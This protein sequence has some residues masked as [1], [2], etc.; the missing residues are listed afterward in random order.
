MPAG[1]GAADFLK[2]DKH[3]EETGCLSLRVRSVLFIFGFFADVFVGD[4]IAVDAVIFKLSQPT[5]AMFSAVFP[6]F[7]LAV[8]SF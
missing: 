2:K 5:V 6:R 8:K 7:E 4:I 3:P 1:Q